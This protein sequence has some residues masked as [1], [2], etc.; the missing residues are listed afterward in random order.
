MLGAPRPRG[1]PP[2][3]APAGPVDARQPRNAVQAASGAAA[4]PLLGLAGGWQPRDA[5]Q[6]SG[7]AAGPLLG[8]AG[9][10]LPA[11]PSSTSA[12][13][14]SSRGAW[15]S[16]WSLPPVPATTAQELPTVAAVPAQEASDPIPA[17]DDVPD[18]LV[19]E[20][21]PS[22]APDAGDQLPTSAVQER[23]SVAGTVD[24]ALV[25]SPGLD[26]TADQ[27]ASASPRLVAAP[28]EP[29][30]AV[31]AD[32]LAAP[33]T[34]LA[35]VAE[36]HAGTSALPQ[37]ASPFC[38]PLGSA[39]QPTWAGECATGSFSQLLREAITEPTSITGSSPRATDGLTLCPLL[40]P[41]PP[42]NR[43]GKAPGGAGGPSPLLRP[44]TA[45]QPERISVQSHSRTSDSSLGTS[46][47]PGLPIL[48]SRGNAFASSGSGGCQPAVPAP[49]T[50]LSRP[51]ESSAAP[52]T[53]SIPMAHLLPTPAEEPAQQQC[54]MGDGGSASVQ[55]QQQEQQAGSMR[56]EVSPRHAP[57][58]GLLTELFMSHSWWQAD[59][60]F[61]LKPSGGR[62]KKVGDRR[63][64]AEDPTCTTIGERPDFPVPSVPPQPTVAARER[65]AQSLR[66]ETELG[67]H[68]RPSCLQPQ[69]PQTEAPQGATPL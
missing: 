28:E 58:R 43:A 41:V 26:A 39:E 24:L 9:G 19:A 8:L 59:G 3:A 12:R 6:V 29:R 18:E 30:A 57:P 33:D 62:A 7:A 35:A 10:S 49:G 11:R 40:L 64:D 36:Q 13:S 69:P 68:T 48:A 1:R 56:E 66:P 34:S 2:R 67:H 16:S 45:M 4:G 27:N 55:Q 22:M 42:P 53:A 61:E 31:G 63:S 51:R 44:A 20:E 25:L 65:L 47:A 21:Q 50:P 60:T 32:L 23:S 15:S 17:D 54:G 38:S 14:G 5:A 52:A 37:P 46:L